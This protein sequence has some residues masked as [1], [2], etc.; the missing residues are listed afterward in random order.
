[1]YKSYHKKIVSSAVLASVVLF[2][3]VC[4]ASTDTQANFSERVKAAVGPA[5]AAVS[6]T[7]KKRY[8]HNGKLVVDGGVTYPIVNGKTGSY[9]VN[10][11]AHSMTIRYGKK[12]TENEQRA[13]DIDVMPDGTGL[14]EGSG[15][16][17]DGDEIYEAKCLSCHGEFGSGSGLYPKLTMG[18]AYEMQKTLKNQRINPDAEGPKRCFGSYWPQASTLWWYIKTG[19]PHN[20]PMSLTDDEVYALCA[21]ILSVNEMEIDGVLVEDDYVLDREKFLKI[22]MPNR[23]GFEP[24]IDGPKGQDNAR[25]YFNEPLNY[26][27]GKRC[28]KDCFEGEPKIQRIKQALT[29]FAPPLSTE[30][31]LPEVK[32]EAKAEHPG[33]KVYAKSC[34]MCH[35]SGAAGAPIVGNAKEWANVLKKGKD[36]VYANAISGVGAMPPKGGAMSLSDADF[37]QVVDYMIESSK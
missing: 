33:K 29:D 5:K 3:T 8:K 26:G 28:M 7:V 30:R 19:M 32:E 24:K 12:A 23:D 2:G 13:W 14:P 10:E 35:D 9:Y 4:H 17:E 15:S 16:V 27:N 37:K 11:K 1:M 25:A 18:N 21:Y 6:D 34:A 20:A 36:K 31:S 22:K